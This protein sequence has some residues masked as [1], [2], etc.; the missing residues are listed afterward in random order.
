MNKHKFIYWTAVTIFL[1]TAACYGK[2]FWRWDS[3]TDSS[4]ALEDIGGKI[5]YSSKINLNGVKGD[6]AVFYFKR[7]ISDV[8]AE[9]RRIFNSGKFSFKGGT[10]QTASIV[11]GDSLLRFVFVQGGDENSAVV[12]KIQQD[13]NEYAES[14]KLSNRSVM[15]SLPSFP[16]STPVFFG[17]DENSKMSMAV[18]ETTADSS[19][20]FD[21]Y[22]TALTGSGWTP[23]NTGS[24]NN[25]K[26]DIN[27]FIRGPEIACVF[28][29]ASGEKNVSRITL[30][31]KKQIVR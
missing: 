3:R 29:E 6:L 7:P 20:V 30:L 27:V 31:Y 4:G 21:Y 15:K 13:K 16:G 5:A 25:R 8:I 23:F 12:F 10:M 11:S 1:V 17:E 18:S 28:V 2:V 22:N 19:G 24:R 9:L 26:A 14:G